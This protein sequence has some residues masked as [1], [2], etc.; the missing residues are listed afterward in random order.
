MQR[1]YT[2]TTLYFDTEYRE[3]INWKRNKDHM[4]ILINWKRNK[5]HMFILIGQI[6]DCI[7]TN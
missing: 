2:A 7:T 1:F 6:R 4:F 5:D 3:I